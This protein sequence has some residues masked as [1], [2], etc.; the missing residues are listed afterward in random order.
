MYLSWHSH[1]TRV[2]QGSRLITILRIAKNHFLTI[3]HPATLFLL[4]QIDIMCI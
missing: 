1:P 2:I 3:F 4:L